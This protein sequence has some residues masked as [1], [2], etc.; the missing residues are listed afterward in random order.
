MA[1]IVGKSTGRARLLTKGEKNALRAA[2]EARR[3]TSLQGAALRMEIH[4]DT[5]SFASWVKGGPAKALD[6]VMQREVASWQDVHSELARFGLELHRTEYGK[7]TG[8]TVSG[9]DERGR[10][11]YAK[12]SEAFS[13]HFAGKKARET[14]AAKLGVWQAPTVGPC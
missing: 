3:G 14:T 2:R 5:E 7:F 13:N 12:A 9:R 11:I 6:A 10:E 8:Y 1:D 4:R